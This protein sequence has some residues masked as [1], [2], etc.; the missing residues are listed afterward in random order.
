MRGA[1]LGDRR[2]LGWFRAVSVLAV[3]AFLGSCGHV[4]QEAESDRAGDSCALVLVYDGHEYVGSRSAT[5][6]IPVRKKA[7]KSGTWSECDRRGVER[8]VVFPVRGFPMTVVVRADDGLG[9]RYAWVR[10]DVVEA[11]HN[12]VENFSPRLRRLFR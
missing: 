11:A 6:P 8:A 7:A 2:C 3:A 4:S 9:N 5:Q 1:E 12:R 10:A